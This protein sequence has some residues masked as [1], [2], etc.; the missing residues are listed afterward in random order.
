VLIQ[1]CISEQ[2]LDS[3]KVTFYY[4]YERTERDQY[5]LA[6][7]RDTEQVLHELERLMESQSPVIK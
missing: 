5:V 1:S 2:L 4:L 3:S 6:Q 7:A